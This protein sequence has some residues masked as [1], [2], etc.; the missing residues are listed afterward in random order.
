MTTFRSVAAAG[1]SSGVAHWEQNFAPGSFSC[2]Q[3]GQTLTREAY[4][5]AT[6]VLSG[7]PDDAAAIRIVAGGDALLSPA[8]TKRVIE[9]FARIPQPSPPKELEDLTERQLDVV[10]PHR[11][12]FSN[13][14]IGQELYISH[15]TV[16]THIT[17]GLF[18]AD[19]ALPS[20][21]DS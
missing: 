14:E 16:K 1:R 17:T 15:T 19:E 8:I 2:P 21:G 9:Q 6:G 5:P 4:A 3:L 18:D 12:G 13:A 10:P 20:G 7:H 11:P